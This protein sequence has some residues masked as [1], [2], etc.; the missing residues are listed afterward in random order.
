MLHIFW[1][2]EAT[3]TLHYQQATNSILLSIITFLHLF[4]SINYSNTETIFV[5]LFSINWR[6]KCSGVASH[7]ITSQGVFNSC[8]SQHASITLILPQF[9]FTSNTHYMYVLNRW[10][11]LLNISLALKRKIGPKKVPIWLDS[12]CRNLEIDSSLK[13]SIMDLS[14]VLDESVN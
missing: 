3:L 12:P 8:L 5:Y 1:V 10:L 2:N 14:K 7:L 6:F 4:K 11:N 9:L 13:P